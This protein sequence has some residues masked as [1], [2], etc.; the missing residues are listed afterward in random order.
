[1]AGRFFAR[2]WNMLHKD[3][4]GA[5]GKDPHNRLRPAESRSAGLDPALPLVGLA[6]DDRSL[7]HHSQPGRTIANVVPWPKRLATE[8]VPPCNSTRDLAMARPSPDSPPSPSL[9]SPPR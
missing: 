1:M 8:I 9:A 4:P 3:M 7:V 6:G 5:Q 2:V